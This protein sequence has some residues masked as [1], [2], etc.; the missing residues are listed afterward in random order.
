VRSRV[1]AGPECFKAI[2]KGHLRKRVNGICRERKARERIPPNAIPR[3]EPMNLE[4][5]KSLIFK[6]GILRFMGRGKIKGRKP[7]ARFGAL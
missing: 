3:F 2:I 7:V 6:D 4:I 1:E 5:H